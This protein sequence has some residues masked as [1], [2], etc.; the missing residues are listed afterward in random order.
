MASASPFYRAGPSILLPQHQLV[1]KDATR[2]GFACAVLGRALPPAR[3][4]QSLVTSARAACFS[5]ASPRQK[6]HF[7][8][9]PPLS[10][11][12]QALEP[13]SPQIR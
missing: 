5:R 6:V 13:H 8:S 2:S 11:N 10:F 9:E 7:T 1:P 12:A 3:P 4:G